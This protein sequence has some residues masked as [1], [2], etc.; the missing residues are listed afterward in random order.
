MASTIRTIKASEMRTSFG[1]QAPYGT[2]AP[3]GMQKFLLLLA[4]GSFLKR[5]LF[6]PTMARLIMGKPGTPIDVD[7]RN[8]QYRLMGSN[9]LI[10]YGMLLN[11][12]YNGEDID[13]LLAQA[14]AGSHFID[15]GSNIGL[16]SLPMA[17]TAA[18]NGIVISIDANPMMGQTLEWSAAA[19]KL[20]NVKVVSCA[21]SDRDGRADL[22]V[23][24]DDVAIVHV[25]ETPDGA[26]PVRTLASI[27]KE[28]G[29]TSIYGLKIDIEGHEDKALVPFLTAA[30]AELL[31]KRIVIEHPRP[32]EDYPGCAAAF[33]ARGYQLKGR[34]Q[35]NSF[36]E[37]H[38]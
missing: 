20:D 9:N 17:K 37:L 33:K 3:R 35:N 18:P 31:P 15:L 6:R 30:P 7:F 21:V 32:Q 19:S 2:Y 36:Y 25:K 23:R 22:M 27:V 11:P 8:C 1:H 24:K 38:I 26:V 16:Y 12:R 28:H 34:N 14:P 5:G 29:L 13:F 4:R 10:E